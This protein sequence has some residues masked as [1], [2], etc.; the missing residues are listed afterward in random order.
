M[1][2]ALAKTVIAIVVLLLYYYCCYYHHHYLSSCLALATHSV[3]VASKLHVPQLQPC[4]VG[5]QLGGAHEG[6]V[7]PQAAVNS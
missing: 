5:V 6:E 4:P 1:N 3:R 7:H 2:Q